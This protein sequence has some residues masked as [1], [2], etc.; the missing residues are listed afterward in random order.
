MF[1]ISL[2]IVF[3]MII[4]GS[5]LGSMA[6]AYACGFGMFLLTMVLGLTPGN[7][8]INVILIIISIIGTIGILELS[9][10]IAYIVKLAERLLRRHS[11]YINIVAPLVNFFM[12]LLTGT[13]HTAYSTIP[14]IIQVAKD[15]NIKP[16]YPLSVSIVA[17][18]LAVIA[19]PIS[20]ATIAM[21]GILQPYNISILQLM[22][23]LI[24]SV[25]F[26][27]ILLG[28]CASILSKPLDKNGKANNV[29][30]A[31]DGNILDKNDKKGQTSV[32]LFLCAI[33]IIMIYSI[34]PQLKP[35]YMDGKTMETPLLIVMVMFSVSLL[36]VLINKV[37]ITEI[38]SQSTFKAGITAVICVIAVAWLG[39]TLILNYKKE[40]IN[41]A[42]NALHAYSWLFF[43][44]IFIISAILYS[45]SATILAI[46]PMGVALGLPLHILIASVVCSSA[47]FVFPTYPTLIAG[48][49]MDDTGS[50]KFGKYVFDHSLIYAGIFGV[51]FATI[52]AYFLSFIVL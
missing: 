51:V 35:V 49:E 15:Q 29:N 30:L 1:I 16:V 42:Q 52:I 7:I 20:A 19:S 27:C 14:V 36:M 32:L 41:L 4:L 10:G 34:F 26:G 43:A 2:L 39:D 25:F 50:T 5:K 38:S 9:G 13:G 40:L 37:K 46:M 8:P 45:Q 48:V 18:Q 3:S 12:A 6:L 21:L 24:P 47:L 31:K 28:I 17:S 11:R 22:A 33:F 23:I 44:V